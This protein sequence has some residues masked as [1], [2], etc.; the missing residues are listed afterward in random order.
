MTNKPKFSWKMFLL[1]LI[2]FVI[3]PIG[4]AFL[5]SYTEGLWSSIFRFLTYFSII[6]AV[7]LIFG[8]FKKKR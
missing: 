1:F 2:G 8:S 5:S 4:F 3:F 7:I 6:V